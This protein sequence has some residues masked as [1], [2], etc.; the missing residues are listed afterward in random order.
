MKGIESMKCKD[1]SCHDNL[2]DNKCGIRGDYRGSGHWCMATIEIETNNGTN[3]LI[4]TRRCMSYSESLKSPEW[5][6]K[7][8]TE[9]IYEDEVCQI[10]NVKTRN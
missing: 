8:S 1:C 3:V 7:N 10:I 4:G 6:P 2:K 9:Y 5:C